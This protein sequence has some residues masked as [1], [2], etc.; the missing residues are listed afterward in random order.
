MNELLSTHIPPQNLTIGLFDSGIGGYSILM[1]LFHTL[2]HGEYFYIADH[3]HSPYGLKSQEFVQERCR[4]LTMEL[5]KKGVDLIVIACNTATVMAIE[6][7]RHEFPHLTFVGI[8][9][10]VNFINRP[11]LPLTPSE[12]LQKKIVVLT[13]VATGNS[14]KFLELKERLDPNQILTH[15]S[16]PNLASLV[17]TGD[18]HGFDDQLKQAVFKELESV[19]LGHFDLAI[20]GCTHYPLVQHWIFE[21]TKAFPIAPSKQVAKQ[22][23]SLL[24]NKILMKSH[25]N[26]K[27]EDSPLHFHFLSTE[28]HSE[29]KGPW[30]L[31]TRDEILNKYQKIGFDLCES[32]FFKQNFKEK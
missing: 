24:Q 19:S 8:E 14:K 27:N 23:V 2:P 18:R 12:L 28:N 4:V 20:L 17:E 3:A 32:T 31:K 13:T 30:I 26:G 5:E 9:P 25:I 29:S 7:L 1:E 16:L 22:V 21:K 15:I 6:Y 10:F 11:S